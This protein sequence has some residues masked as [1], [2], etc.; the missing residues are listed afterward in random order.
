MKK[1][2]ALFLVA[3]TASGALLVQ[4]P[5][6]AWGGGFASRHPRRAEVLRRDGFQ[7]NELRADRGMLGGH[8]HQLMRED[9]GIARQERRDARINGGFITRGQQN[10]LN[11]EENR[12]QRQ[13]NRDFRY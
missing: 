9:R 4:S 2:S 7:R 5:S 3:V 10:Q 6:F 13:M 8:Y 12:V 1:I 11:R